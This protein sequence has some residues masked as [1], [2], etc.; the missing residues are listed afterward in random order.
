[1]NSRLRAVSALLVSASALL[2]VAAAPSDPAYRVVTVDNT[3]PRR[4]IFGVIV[5]AHDG[6]L[7]FADGRYYLYGTAYGNSAGFGINN[8]FRIYSSPDLEHWTFEGEALNSPPDGVHYNPS[9]VYNPRTRKYVFW[10][11]WYP[12]LWEGQVGVAVSDTPFG[13]FT[14]VNTRVALTQAGRR[15]GAGTLFVDDDGSGYYIYTA[16][17][18]DHAVRVERLTPDFLASTGQVSDVIARG[19][20]ATSMLK[21]AG[22]YYALF[23]TT[24]CFCKE[25]SGARFYVAANPLGPYT[26]KG[27]INRDARGQPIVPAQQAS[28]ARIPTREGEAL[29]WIADRWGSRRD[30]IKGHDLQFWSAPLRFDSAGNILPVEDLPRFSLDLR[31]AAT[32]ARHNARPYIWP[33]RHDPHPLKIDPCT[34]APL[35]AEN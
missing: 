20:E 9:V 21:H 12:T 32:P 14:I 7:L 22:L 18:D 2:A 24:C 16:I 28:I 34:G 11:N 10:Y 27:N 31:V 4:D 29:I 33:R 1:M 8:R 23:D 26:L 25:G 30:G 15:P 6:N 17:S 35:P 19:C 3:A 5:D 13:P